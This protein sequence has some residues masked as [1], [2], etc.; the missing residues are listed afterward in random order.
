MANTFITPTAVSREFLR[1]LHSMVPFCSSI[2]RQYDNSTEFGGV[3]RGQ[4]INIRKPTKYSIRTGAVAN[5]Q[6]QGET[7]SPLTVD[8]QIGVDV[9]FS[10]AE[11][12][13]TLDDFSKRVITPAASRMAAELESLVMTK[14][15]TSTFNQVGAAGTIP[16]SALVYL[17]AGQKLDEFLALRDNKRCVVINPAAQ[18]NSVDALKGL[19]NPTGT[20]GGQYKNGE[21]GDGLGFMFKM[22]QLVPALTTGDRL[23]AASTLVDGTVA[24]QGS[25]TIHVDGFTGATATV[26]EG[27]IIT[28]AGVYA[29]NE[30]G[31]STGNLQQF[32]VTADATAA[33]NEVDLLVQPAMYT[34]G[35]KKNISAFPTDEGVVTFVGSASTAYTQNSAHHESAYTLATVDLE[36]PKGVDFAGREAMDGISIR[37]VRDFDVINDVFITRFD[38]LFGSVAQRPELGCRIIGN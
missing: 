33:S 10:S 35:A 12:T 38:L 6:D 19:F 18:A 31:A 2:D 32:V 36:V 5:V 7:F 16:Q 30:A 11:M 8:Q 14:M 23:L 9:S 29:V 20:I 26:K 34:T 4:T 15:M 37:V 22:G 3:K 24:T 21:M 13:Q 1:V 17:Q 25:T 28:V 27:E